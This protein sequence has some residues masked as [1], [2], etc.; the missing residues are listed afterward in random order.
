[1]VPAHNTDADPRSRSATIRLFA[2]AS[3][4]FNEMSMFIEATSLPVFALTAA[5]ILGC[6]S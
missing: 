1:M 2:I 5:S 3:F 4:T 6:I